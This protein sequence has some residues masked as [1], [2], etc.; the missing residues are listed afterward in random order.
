MYFNKIIKS[1]QVANIE[2]YYNNNYN[3]YNVPCLFYFGFIFHGIKSIYVEYI[4]L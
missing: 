3:P 1:K 2:Y 4:L